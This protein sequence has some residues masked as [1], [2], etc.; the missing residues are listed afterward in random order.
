MDVNTEWQITD[1]KT[2]ALK[3]RYFTTFER[4][5]SFMINPPTVVTAVIPPG[6]TIYSG[7]RDNSVVIPTPKGPV[8]VSAKDS[9]FNSRSFNVDL[10]NFDLSIRRRAGLTD[11]NQR[12]A[13]VIG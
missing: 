8:V 11:K 4:Y 13:A 6:G 1:V 3:G 10:V 9:I 5:Q 12:R 2:G 7:P